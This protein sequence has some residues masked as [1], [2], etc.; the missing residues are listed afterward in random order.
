MRWGEYTHT[1]LETSTALERVSN[2]SREHRLAIEAML[3][4]ET[5]VFSGPDDR[6]GRRPR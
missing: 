3:K 2:R 5:P 4:K 1:V 6:S